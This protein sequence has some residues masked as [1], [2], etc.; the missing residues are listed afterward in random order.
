[1]K[2][3]ISVLMC[4]LCIALLAN[5]NEAQSLST[6]ETGLRR[7]SPPPSVLRVKSEDP[8][9]LI[10]SFSTEPGSQCTGGIAMMLELT[11]PPNTLDFW[12]KVFKYLF[13]PDPHALEG[14][15]DKQYFNNRPG[16]IM[17]V[18]ISSKGSPRQP[19]SLRSITSPSNPGGAEAIVICMDPATKPPSVFSISVKFKDGPN[20]SAPVELID[21][22]FTAAK[23]SGSQSPSLAD[24]GAKPGEVGQRPLDRNLDLGIA[25]TSARETIKDPVTMQNRIE[26]NNRGV[27]DVR[28]I[29]FLNIRRNQVPPFTQKWFPFWTPIFLDANVST[30]KIITETL[31][32]NRVEFGT[33]LEYRFIPFNKRVVIDRLGNKRAETDTGHYTTFYRFMFKGKHISDRDFKQKEVAASVE[34]QPMFAAL[35]HPIE[36]N[37]KPAQ[38][39]ISGAFV[40]QRGTYG[41][42]FKPVFG[43]DFGRTYSRDNPAMAI[44]P[45]PNIRRFY[46][47]LDVTF[48]ITSRLKLTFTDTFY[49]R[50]ESEENRKK[51]YFKGEI[52]LPIDNPF[53]NTS[54]AIFANYENGNKPPFNKP[55]VSGFRIGYRIRSTGWFGQRR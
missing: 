20:R 37:W 45:S 36:A 4:V 50:G 16:D 2:R 40:F 1:M 35:N 52:L 32:L 31:S 27:L 18:E 53:G 29:P 13:E 41:W 15:D 54:Q 46:T 26:R 7:E 43:F 22:P 48:D 25:F 49:V 28:F 24:A 44:Q 12:N 17:L 5:R 33:D 55:D 14:Q 23:V 6:K 11:K 9:P 47:T 10:A 3:S 8:N 34:F 30:G 42:E 38:D 21:K 51:N 19:L 39:P